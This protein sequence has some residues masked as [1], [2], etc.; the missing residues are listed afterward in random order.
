MTVL[1]IVP[2]FVLL[3]ISIPEVTNLGLRRHLSH[4]NPWSF[5]SSSRLLLSLLGLITQ[6]VDLGCLLK[7]RHIEDIPLVESVTPMVLIASFIFII[8]LL[9]GNRRKGVIRSPGV[10][11]FY[12]VATVLEAINV[13]QLT[14]DTNDIR[15]EEYYLGLVYFSILCISLLFASIPDK[16]RPLIDNSRDKICPLDSASV[17]SILTFYWVYPL[18]F[19][20]WKKDLTKDDVPPLSE[21]DRPDTLG[22]YFRRFLFKKKLEKTR[23]NHLLDSHTSVVQPADI[24][25]RGIFTAVL[26]TFCGELF[27]GGILKLFTD[28]LALANPWLLKWLLNFVDHPNPEVDKEPL[29]HGLFIVVLMFVT[30]SIQSLFSSQYFFVGFR[31]GTRATAAVQTSVYRKAISIDNDVRKRTTV[32]EI[33]NLMSVDAGRFNFSMSYFHL[34]WAAPLQVG[35][36]IYLLYL[37]L[38]VSCL[39]GVGVLILL[40]PVNY[41]VSKKIMEVVKSQMEIKDERIKVMNEILSGI[42]V[43]KL[44]AWEEAFMKRVMSIRNKECVKILKYAYYECMSAVLWAAAPLLTALASFTFFILIDENN[45]LNAEKVFVSLALFNLLRQPL[46]HMPAL[47]S[48]LVMMITSVKR[49]NRFFSSPDLQKYVTRHHNNFAVTF[50]KAFFSWGVQNQEEEDFLKMDQKKDKKKAPDSDQNAL[51]NKS[52][53]TLNSLVSTEGETSRDTCAST[54]FQLADIT[55]NISD[56]SL[57]AVVGVVGS[58]KSSFLSALLGEMQKIRGS[59]NIASTVKN[60]AYVSQEAWIQNIT[61]KDNI[62][63]GKQYNES[64][65]QNILKVCELKPDLEILPAGDMTEIG[66]KGINLSGGQK[67]RLNLAR[68]CY[69]DSDLYLLDDP[70]SAVDSHVAKNLF[71]NVIG[72][73]G[74][75]GKKTRILVTN[76]L[77]ILPQVD[78]IV[79]LKDGRVSEVGTYNELTRREGDFADFIKTFATTKRRKSVS[80]SDSTSSPVKSPDETFRSRSLSATSKTSKEEEETTPTVTQAPDQLIAEENIEKGSVKW[81]VYY[82]YLK[83]VSWSS[84][85]ILFLIFMQASDVSSSI[86]LANWSQDKVNQSSHIFPNLSL[87]EERLIVYGILG[88]LTSLFLFLS[89]I[90]MA[91]GSVDACMKFHETMLHRILRCPMSFFETTPIGRIVNRF[92]KDMDSVDLTLGGILLFFILCC[93]QMIPTFTIIVFVTPIFATVIIPSII[94]YLLVQKFYIHTQRQLKRLESATR[95]PVYSHF[96]ETLAGAAT[97]RAFAVDDQFI[98]DSDLKVETN[99]KCKFMIVALT[100]WLGL[101]LSFIGNILVFLAA[102]FAVLSRDN[103][104]AGL[105]GLAITYSMQIS[106]YL[107]WFTELF[108]IVETEIVSVERIL[109]YSNNPTEAEWRISSTAPPCDWPSKGEVEFVKHAT[110]Y[111]P[112][113]DLVLH[114]ISFKIQSKEK[115]GIVGRT[116]AGKSSITLSLLRII[117][118]ASGKIIIDGIDISKIGLHDLRSRLTIIPQDPVLFSGTLR[119]NIDPFDTKS[120]EEIWK[121]LDHAHLKEFVSGLDKG[122]DYEISEGGGNLSV[123]QRQLVCMA[124]AL[125]RKT[126]VLILDEAT[127]SIDLETDSLIQKTIRSEFADCTVLTIAHRLHTILDSSRVLVLD[128]GRVAEFDTPQNLL[129]DSNSVFHSLAKDAGIL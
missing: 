49:L 111:R 32:G 128:S 20:G 21:Q 85:V 45:V 105:T 42:K 7:N 124:R 115:I 15:D 122:L 63:F 50:D 75:L 97:I 55:L 12:A 102:L 117:E 120:D 61:L 33:V 6:A 116:G 91:K 74:I 100:R 39:A 77:S 56:Q 113:L 106:Q 76:H 48:S 14:V 109:E 79:V 19:L 11:I 10:W 119:F 68:A 92:S 81:S 30:N 103:L 31:L 110:R 114:D 5:V 27:L 26:S 35:I 17:P 126:R 112:G 22:P 107:S 64:K 1:R 3:F 65:Y 25:N 67:Q 53:S 34:I 58:G 43:L 44:Y 127:A 24:R 13:Y 78:Q 125:L 95:S 2:C 101:I 99:Q 121:S 18:L 69:S 9:N 80:K 82:Q 62:L 123:G 37:E 51:I 86:W 71:D 8:L 47:M 129:Q 36:I 28:M 108:G 41:H 98:G 88:S 87:R 104:N 57:V 89:S 70:L 46:S 40:L 52:C 54:S 38:G 90:I 59:V 96:S 66:E 23:V 84:V 73:K 16:Y 83:A 93:C 94:T 118:A 4:S 60:L 29:W 72:P